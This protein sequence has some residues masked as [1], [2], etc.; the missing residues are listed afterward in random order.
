[1]EGWAGQDSQGLLVKAHSETNARREDIPGGTMIGKHSVILCLLLSA[2]LSASVTRGASTVA[3][4]GVGEVKDRRFTEIRHLDM[5]Y[6]Y[7]APASREEW[8]KRAEYLRE[9]I[10]TGAGLLPMPE[11]TP[12]NARIFG[13]LDRGDYIIEKV[14]FESFPGFYVTGNLYR[15]KGR[16]G[17][18]PLV[19][20]PHGHATE[21]RLED[22]ERCSVLARCANFAKQGYIAFAYDMVGY[23]DSK[24]LVHREDLAGQ[25]EHLWG[26]SM[27]G[28]QL[29]NSI[30]VVDFLC[31]LPDADPERI[32]CTGNSGGGTQTFML[33]AVDPRI[34]ASAPVCM[35]SSYMQGGCICENPPLVRLDTNNMEIG[36]LA[37]PRP[38]ILI[39]AT[40]DW[41]NKT[42][43]VEFPAI[44]GV[45]A[46]YGAEDKV[47][48][49]LIDAGHHYNKAGRESVYAWF[50]RWI[51]GD[52]NAEHFREKPH[53][54]ERAEDL[55]VFAN[56]PK[57]SNMLTAQDFIESRIKASKD[58]ISAMKPHDA[59][60][61]RRFRE[62]YGR[63]LMHALGIERPALE[64]ITAEHRGTEDLT[65]CRIERLVIGRKDKGDAIPAI[66]LTPGGVRGKSP[67]TVVI[68][69]EGKS[70][71]LD[72]GRPGEL[73]RRLLKSGHRV[74]A[75]DCFNT[76]EHRGPAESADRLTR[77]KFFDT[78]NRTDTMN[79]VQ[80]I[81]TVATFAKKAATAVN[82]VGI[83][84][85]G[86]WCMLARA[87]ADDI[88][89][90]A[91]DAHGFDNESDEQFVE[92]LYAPSLRR[93]GDFRT[94]AALIA[95]G[96]IFIHNTRGRFET[97]W[98]EDVYCVGETSGALRFRGTEASPA[99]IVQWLRG[100]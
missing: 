94:A 4:F 49:N 5:I 87:F 96:R 75:A 36:A 40:G 81:V 30:R 88:R 93:A 39:A 9:Q 82:M 38:L 64:E 11:K 92:K 61:L 72:D 71:L 98:I 86:L 47:S 90:V 51:L 54:P 89:S 83:G 91:V 14:Y 18:Y 59:E 42:P 60:S 65:D 20:S 41:T 28:L 79:R 33:T 45:Y 62:T 77:Y 21:G 26:I 31:S 68:H 43:E 95:P 19:L 67:V 29:W 23:N 46:L 48:C 24:Q 53:H 22:T 97:D 27:G 100:K 69:A 32:A 8:E 73:I 58:Q 12:L 7:S 63:A 10:L 74:L 17:P 13:L 44:R 56:E 35:I 50:G 55:L 52:T 25:R 84:E 15:P 78:Y 66:L 34:K 85:A 37:A 80:D 2:G 1:M 6:S 16:T 3:S 57:P 76:G 99:E 70:A